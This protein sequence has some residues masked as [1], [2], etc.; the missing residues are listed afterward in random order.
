MEES[1]EATGG[2][3]V[4]AA[5]DDDR[6]LQDGRIVFDGNTQ[7]VAVGAE[8]WRER[9]GERDEPDLGVAGVSILRGLG[10]VFCDAEM[11]LDDGGEAEVVERGLGGASVGRVLGIGDGD[12]LDGAEGIEGKRGDAGVVA[13]PEDEGSARVDEG[14]VLFGF[15]GVDD[16]LGERE[17]G[18]HEEIEGGAVND[19]C[20]KRG[21]RLVG[22]EDVDAGLF[23]ELVEDGG[24]DGLEIGGGGEA[25]RLLREEVGGK[26]E[27]K[28]REGEFDGD[29]AGAWPESH[30]CQT[31]ADM[32]HPG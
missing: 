18:G 20:G 24:E 29:K 10:N 7:E 4:R 11:W 8:A 21:G 6:A 27:E 23:F 5:A 14:V 22:G 13:G 1:E 16:A 31:R 15:S 19:L 26:A 17:V 25:H 3:G 9:G 28:E 30:I 12:G 2:V 32:G